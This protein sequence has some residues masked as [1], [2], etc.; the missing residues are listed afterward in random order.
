MIGVWKNVQRSYED[1]HEAVRRGRF[2]DV[3]EAE[4]NLEGHDMISYH[5]IS[6]R[7]FCQERDP[8]NLNAQNRGRI[9]GQEPSNPL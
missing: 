3:E 9:G 7:D 1:V 2:F 5:M 6:L 8:E 4:T